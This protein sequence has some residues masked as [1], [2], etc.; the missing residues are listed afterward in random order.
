MEKKCGKLPDEEDREQYQRAPFQLAASSGPAQ[1]SGHGSGK[2]SNKRADWRDALQWGIGGE[3]DDRGQE[4]QQ[5]GQRIREDGQIDRSADRG[6]NA[7][8]SGMK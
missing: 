5:S 2:S 6:K 8:G 7:N 3:V 1:N 4:R